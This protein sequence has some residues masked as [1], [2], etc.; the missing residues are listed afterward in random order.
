MIENICPLSFQFKT[1]EH[2]FIDGDVV[3]L[4]NVKLIHDDCQTCPVHAFIHKWS[5]VRPFQKCP[6]RSDLHGIIA[7]LFIQRAYSIGFHASRCNIFGEVLFFSRDQMNAFIGLR[8]ANDTTA[9]IKIRRSLA[10]LLKDINLASRL[11]MHNLIHRSDPEDGSDY[12]FDF[13][14]RCTVREVGLTPSKDNGLGHKQ[15]GTAL[16]ILPDFSTR[17]EFLHEKWAKIVE[18]SIRFYEQEMDS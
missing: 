7:H 9:I 10:F 11:S 5:R 6:E 16:W 15:K 2:E 8:C 3:L 18:Q 4:E 13:D 17:T 14:S 1:I 12:V